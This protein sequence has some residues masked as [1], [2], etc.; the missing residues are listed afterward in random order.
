MMAWGSLTFSLILIFLAMAVMLLIHSGRLQKRTGMPGGQVIY[1][2]HETWYP[3]AESL[4][5]SKHRLVGKPDYLVQKINGEIIPVEVK[6]RLAPKSP[7][8]GHVLQL[9]AYCMLVEETY[10]RRPSYGILHYKDRAFAIDYTEKL[11]QQLLDLLIDMRHDHH[12]ADL[13]RTHE[14][15]HLC[16]AC[17]FRERCDQAIVTEEPFRQPALLK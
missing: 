17:G 11:E 6:S 8:D 12:A 7:L 3:N 9:A 16:A 2:D 15:L 13:D 10:G 1:S 4:H 5:S 14:N